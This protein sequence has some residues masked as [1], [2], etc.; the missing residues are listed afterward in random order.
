MIPPGGAEP[1]EC[2]HYG[3]EY[4]VEKVMETGLAE[5]QVNNVLRKDERPWT[6]G[7]GKA[8]RKI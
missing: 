4:F 8:R 2:W 3:R 6:D 7:G 5:S 1:G